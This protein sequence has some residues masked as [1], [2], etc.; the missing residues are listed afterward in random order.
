MDQDDEDARLAVQP[1]AKPDPLKLPSRSHP[2][3]I[4]FL[5]AILLPSQRAFIDR[6]KEAVRH[7]TLPGQVL[8]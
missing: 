4:Y 1:K 5:P 3:P 2:P 7:I 8:Y 6:K